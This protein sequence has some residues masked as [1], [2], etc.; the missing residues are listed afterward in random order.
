MSA[1]SHQGQTTF[2]EKFNDDE[3]RLLLEEDREA[4]LGIS[5]ILGTLIAIGML[6]GIMSVVLIAKF[7]LR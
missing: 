4:Q 6:L 7:G 3:R 5:A 2:E 1:S